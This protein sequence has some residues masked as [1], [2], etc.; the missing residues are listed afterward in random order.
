MLDVFDQI[1]TNDSIGNWLIEQGAIFY[2]TTRFCGKT[3]SE[4]GYFFDKAIK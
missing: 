4:L 3:V 2:L 1:P